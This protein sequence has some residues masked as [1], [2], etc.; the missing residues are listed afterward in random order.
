MSYEEKSFPLEKILTMNARDY[1]DSKDKTLRDYEI[2]GVHGNINGDVKDFVN[3]IPKD[4]EIVVD[5]R[6]IQEHTFKIRLYGT[7]LIPKAKQEPAEV[8]DT[9][10]LVS[11]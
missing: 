6:S 10:G 8:P 5:Y 4:T 2:V 1:C 9:G 3:K 11:R 7:A